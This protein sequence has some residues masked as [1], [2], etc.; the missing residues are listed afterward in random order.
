MTRPP[1]YAGDPAINWSLLKLLDKSPAHY[2]HALEHPDD[3]DTASRHLLRAVHM[4]VLEPERAAREVVVYDGV[5][6]GKA[7]DE[8]VRE[9]A[10]STILNLRETA[11]VEAVVAAVRAHPVASALLSGGQAE[12]VL[13]WTDAD[14]GRPCKGIADYLH[15]PTAD[16]PPVIVDL[17]GCQSIDPVLFSRDVARMG[18]HGQM[19]HYAAGVEALC[20]VAPIVY[21][22]GYETAAP[23]DVGVFRLSDDDLWLGGRMRRRLLDRLIEC[24]RTDTW[25]GRLP[26][27]AALDLP[28]WIWRRDDPDTD[29]DTNTDNEW[30]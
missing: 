2:R 29:D 11:H 30:E 24:E 1:D 18:Y 21:L 7:W 20:G 26:D 12:V 13:R 22:V 15:A 3:G 28:S 6:R 17:K 8:F 5:R 16:H 23:H 4:G 27:V 25:P 10:G 14:T 19:A 9:H